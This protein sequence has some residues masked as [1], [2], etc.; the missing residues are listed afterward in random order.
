MFEVHETNKPNVIQSVHVSFET[1]Y[2]FFSGCRKEVDH[3]QLLLKQEVFSAAPNTQLPVKTHQ[4]RIYCSTGL[5]PP[6]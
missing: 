6:T 1:T 5:L 3:H 4:V 2:N